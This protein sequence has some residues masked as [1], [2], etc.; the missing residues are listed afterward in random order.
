MNCAYELMKFLNKKINTK[1]LQNF[2]QLYSEQEILSNWQ[3]MSEFVGYFASLLSFNLHLARY[4]LNGILMYFLFWLICSFPLEVTN[5]PTEIVIC[6]HLLNTY[7]SYT[8]TPAQ[9]LFL[10]TTANIEI[11]E[12]T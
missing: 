6:I 10:C 1:W 3:F 7:N 12:G 4:L 8:Y 11:S 5:K 2:D 9:Q